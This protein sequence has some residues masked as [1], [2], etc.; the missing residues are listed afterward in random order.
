M[1]GHEADEEIPGNLGDSF[2]QVGK[3]LPLGQVFSIGVDI[4]TKQCDFLC[5]ALNQTAALGENI[6]KFPAALPA[7]DV[8]HDAVGAEI[9]AAVHDGH[10]RL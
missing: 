3:I 5:A 2:Q 7:P 10:P 6:L 9:V 8:G 1:T 4:L